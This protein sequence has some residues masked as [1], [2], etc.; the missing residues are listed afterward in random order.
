M[1]DI[2]FLLSEKEYE[3]AR[4]NIPKL[5]I[6]YWLRP[7]RKGYVQWVSGSWGPQWAG[8]NI[9][10]K[11]V[12][13]WPAIK[14]SNHPIGEKIFRHNFLWIVISDKLAI[15]KTPIGQYVY[16]SEGNYCYKNSEI[17][18]YLFDWLEEM[19]VKRSVKEPALMRSCLYPGMIFRIEKIHYHMRQVT[20][21][22][23]LGVFDTIDAKNAEFDFTDMT[24]FEKK[25]FE[26]ALGVAK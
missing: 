25:R 21:E 4:E 26:R 22:K 15:A 18:R 12:W 1:K 20:F 10:R 14:V 11:D 16:D 3:A 19:T 24:T 7:T 8:N 2:I 5:E 13:V 6:D 9:C 17:R 23:E